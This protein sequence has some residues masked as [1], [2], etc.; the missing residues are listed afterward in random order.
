MSKLVLGLANL[1]KNYGKLKNKLPAKEF[2]KILSKKNFFSVDT[3]I[4]YKNVNILKEEKKNISII[5][6]LPSLNLK[7]DIRNQIFKLVSNYFKKLDV[8]KI[9][10][11]MLHRPEQLHSSKGLDIYLT[12]K[13]LKKKKIIKNF[14]YSLYD[15]TSLNIFINKFKPDILQ[16]PLNILNNKFTTKK[17]IKLI[18]EKNIKI[19]VRSIFLQG[20]LINKNKIDKYLYRLK[21][22][23]DIIKIF[24]RKHKISEL[25]CC[26]NFIKSQK[27]I[28]KVIVGCN[29]LQNYNEIEK[30]FKNKKYIYPKIIFD[31]KEKRLIDPRNWK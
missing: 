9:D 3:A 15:D 29:S 16:I 31:N 17:N 27:Y 13:D 12:L 26:V 20:T 1:N 21:K 5:S 18:K 19:H 25:D 30:S 2:R 23:L 7:K 11:L 10:T 24:S 28:D 22:Y 4:L 6:K 14:G 8:K